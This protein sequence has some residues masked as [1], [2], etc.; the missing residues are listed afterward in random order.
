ME[1]SSPLAGEG[2]EGLASASELSRSWVRGLRRRRAARERCETELGILRWALCRARAPIG[3]PPLIQ[4]RLSSLRSLR[5]RNLLPQGEKGYFF[6]LV[7]LIRVCVSPQLQ[8]GLRLSR[9]A[10]RPS[11]PSVEARASAMRQAVSRRS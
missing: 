7:L 3:A 11:L 6:G 10:A 2:C 4:L 1:S 8:L 5:L 9:K